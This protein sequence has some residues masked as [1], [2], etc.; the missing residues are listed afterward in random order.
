MN[1]SIVTSATTTLQPAIDFHLTSPQVDIADSRSI[2]SQP[3]FKLKRLSHPSAFLIRNAPITS[4]DPSSATTVSNTAT[5]A[6]VPPNQAID[7]LNDMSGPFFCPYNCDGKGLNGRDFLSHAAL[8]TDIY[9]AHSDNQQRVFEWATR[10]SGVSNQVSRLKA[11]QEE[12][13]EDQDPVPDQYRPRHHQEMIPPGL[14]DS[15]NGYQQQQVQAPQAEPSS[16]YGQPYQTQGQQANSTT[17]NYHLRPYP[18]RLPPPRITHNDNDASISDMAASPPPP[19]APTFP[20]QPS[21]PASAL[22]PTANP[23]YP[24]PG[25]GARPPLRMSTDTNTSTNTNSSTDT[26]VTARTSA[27][28]SSTTSSTTHSNKR[29]RDTTTDDDILS[30]TFQ[31]EDEQDDTVTQ[32]RFYDANTV[33]DAAREDENA[34]GEQAMVEDDNHNEGE[35]DSDEDGDAGM[36]ELNYSIFRAAR[37]SNR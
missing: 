32:E 10:L 20:L 13:E 18:A 35:D 23:Y 31:Q 4:T 34:D 26:F 17:P 37:T 11:I 33:P 5:Q 24:S 9:W 7:E 8:W 2:T 29:K 36:L 14:S 1:A 25:T 28:T 27:S 3:L 6:I 16:Y 21:T 30:E 12:E 22:N 15:R 19:S